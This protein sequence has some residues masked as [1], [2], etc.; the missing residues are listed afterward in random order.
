VG[1][2]QRKFSIL[3]PITKKNPLGQI[4][5]CHRSFLNSM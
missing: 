3:R 4:F 5:F 1:K 2:L